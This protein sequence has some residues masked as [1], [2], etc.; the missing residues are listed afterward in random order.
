MRRRLGV[1]WKIP[2]AITVTPS[3]TSLPQT[4]F[5]AIGSIISTHEPAAET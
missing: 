5:R 4:E 3:T 2:I 1:E